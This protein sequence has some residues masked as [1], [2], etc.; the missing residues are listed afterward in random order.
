M[1]EEYGVLKESTSRQI[2]LPITRY[3][4]MGDA[5]LLTEIEKNTADLIQEVEQSPKFTADSKSVFIDLLK[6]INLVVL[7]ELRAAGKLADPQILLMNNEKEISGELEIMLGLVGRSKVAT[8]ITRTQY[9]ITL[10]SIQS[11][12][13]KLTLTRESYFSNQSVATL[14]TLKSYHLGL[15][16]KITQLSTL[17]A[18]SVYDKNND[19]LDMSD[20]MGWSENEDEGDDV[21]LEHLSELSSL[22]NRYLKELDNAQ[23]FIQQKVEAGIK[24]E[25]EMAAMQHKLDLLGETVSTRY[26]SIEQQFYLILFV[27][28]TLVVVIDLLLVLLKNHL[29]KIINHTCEHLNLLASGSFQTN[30]ELNSR[31]DEV[32]GLKQSVSQL[33]DFLKQLVLQVEQETATLSHCQQVVIDGSEHMEFVLTE[34]QKLCVLSAS[35]MNELIESFH[36]VAQNASGTRNATSSTQESLEDGVKKCKV[37][38]NKPMNWLK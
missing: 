4:A 28:I 32:R 18:L 2:H 1:V 29:A 25:K 38:E 8:E 26:K 11:L 21:S 5:S 37:L 10:S 30:F 34:Q 16:E 33:K 14:K 20:L 12:L 6:D 27:C 7:K 3:L 15:T 23:R 31:L 17:P 35:Q 36:I 24:T 13:H 9:Y 19:E 22:V